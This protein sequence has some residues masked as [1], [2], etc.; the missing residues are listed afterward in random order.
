LFV[1]SIASLLAVGFLGTS[2]SE[3]PLAHNGNLPAYFVRVGPSPWL[4]MSLLLVAVLSGALMLVVAIRAMRRG[5]TVPVRAFALMGSLGAL[6]MLLCPPFG[7]A[8]YTNYSAYGHIQNRGLDAY[9]VTPIQAAKLGVPTAAAVEKPWKGTQSVY[10]PASVRIEQAVAAV[11]GSSLARSSLLFSLL[12]CLAFIGT[13]LIL[14]RM[15]SAS[16]NGGRAAVLWLANPLMIDELVAGSH[17]DAIVVFLIVAGFAVLRRSRFL[18]GLLVGIGVATKVNAVL[19]GLGMAW[20]DRRNPKKLVALALG[21]LLAVGGLYLTIS[22]HSLDQ[23]RRASKFVSSS[24]PWWP[25]STTLRH[26]I[27][28]GRAPLVISAGVLLL[29]VFLGKAVIRL[30]PERDDEVGRAARSSFVYTVA[31]LF[32]APYLLPWYDSMAWGTAPLVEDSPVD[33]LLVAH[34]TLLAL[35]ALPGRVL[36]FPPVFNGVVVALHSVIAPIGLLVIIV[37]T[38]RRGRARK[39]SSTVV[40]PSSSTPTYVETPSLVDSVYRTATGP[41]RSATPSTAA[42]SEST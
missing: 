21:G 1:T 37:V 24:T 26:A 15:A 42:T 25:L 36:P 23:T 34:T 41:G 10:G 2:V 32:A 6:A 17:V 19:A 28:M 29:A 16:G 27:G 38:L 11:A 12:H 30:V 9:V 5:W 7:S 3:P 35:G 39:R 20:A 4:V 18:A 33:M 14:I 22:S 13:G 40:L 31:W 8:D